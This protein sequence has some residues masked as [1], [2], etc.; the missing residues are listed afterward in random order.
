MFE[1]IVMMENLERAAKNA[2]RGK[3]SK[4]TAARFWLKQESELR[5]IRA[6]LLDGHYP[7]GRYTEFLIFDKGVQR[8]ISAAP[9]ADRVVH[10]AIMQI[11]EPLF[12]PSFIY[13]SYANRKGKGVSAALERARKFARR[14]PWVLRLDIQ[15]YF[16]SIDHEILKAEL[17]KKIDCVRTLG[18][19]DDLIDASN[20]Q[21]R[22]ERYFPGDHLFTPLERRRGIPLGNLTSQFFGNLY[23]NSFD[24]RI[25]EELRFRGYLRYVDDLVLFGKS[26]ETL[27]AQLDSI[28]TILARLRLKLH[29]E[30]IHCNQS[31]EGF[32]FLGHKIYPTHFRALSKTIRR[33]RRKLIDAKWDY[34]RGKASLAETKNR[35]FGIIGFLRM[36]SNASIIDTLLAQTVLIRPVCEG[37]TAPT[38][39]GAG[40]TGP[41]TPARPIATGTLRT[42]GTTTWVSDS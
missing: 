21:E 41:R 14:D 24:H 32:D 11:I 7:F 34:A 16:P 25:K 18:L 2:M 19:L 39:V 15:K 31:A 4:Q 42:T 29:P 30:K 33:S 13:D 20:L 37:G 8:K 3:K 26:R 12:E 28:K 17:R 5:R 27:E 1:R 6:L 23:L 10:H 38:A 35:L 36:G 40:T 9:F 22:M